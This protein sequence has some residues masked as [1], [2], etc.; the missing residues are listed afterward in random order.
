MKK[1]LPYILILI[2]LVGVFGYGQNVQAADPVGTCTVGTTFIEGISRTQC[3]A[4][5]SKPENK[6]VAV[7][8]RENGATTSVMI[9]YANA[10]TPIPVGSQALPT[11]NASPF[12]QSIDSGCQPSGIFSSDWSFGGCLLKF[13]YYFVFQLSSGLL[14][15]AAQIFN[16]LIAIVIQSKFY[17][18]PFISTAWVVVRDLSN[19]FFILV[20]LYIAVRTILGLGGHDT[21]KMITSV[22]IMALLIN[23]S[24]FFTRIVIDSSNILALIFYNKLD[25]TYE[26][27]PGVSANRPNT[28]STPYN[29]KDISGAMYKNFNATE[30][31]NDTFITKL[32]TQQVVQENAS[33]N[34]TIEIPSSGLPV[35]L[36]LLIMFVAGIIMF[37][38]AYVF[39]ISGLFFLGRLID[40]WVLMIFAPFAFMSF[41]VPSLAHVEYIGWDNWSKKLISTSFMAPIFMFFLY[42]IFQLLKG[43]GIFSDFTSGDGAISGML[44]VFI[45]ALIILGLLSKAKEFAKKGGGQFG[46]IMGKVGGLAAG[47]AIGGGVGLAAKSLQ[48]T[49]GYAGSKM[50]NEKNLARSQSDKWS[51]RVM[52]KAA[53]WTGKKAGSS[54]FDLRSGLA[55]VALKGVSTATGLN[56]GHGSK[57]LSTEKGGYIEDVKRRNDERL[58]EAE[59]VKHIAGHHA[60]EKVNKL[61]DKKQ[62]TMDA[63][64]ETGEDAGK[65]IESVL[66]K[67]AKDI[68][69]TRQKKK[70]YSNATTDEGKA[71]YKKYEE[72]LQ[73]LYAKKDRIQDG[74]EILDKEGKGTGRYYTENGN[75]SETE[76]KNA[77]KA[78]AAARARKESAET[79]KKAAETELTAAETAKKAA[80]SV[81]FNATTMSVTGPELEAATAEVAKM[82]AALAKALEART[83]AEKE[84]TAAAAN[85]TKTEEEAKR[86]NAI[87]TK[88]GGNTKNSI[89][90]IDDFLIPEAENKKKEAET[91]AARGYAKRLEEDWSIHRRGELMDSARNIRIKAKPKEAHKEKKGDDH[92]NVI[93]ELVLETGAEIAA[94]AVT[95]GDKGHEKTH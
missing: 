67:I 85:I 46:E 66:E 30:L 36:T 4:E 31:L 11:Q 24:L 25:V 55:G 19:V 38:A 43:G 3:T 47:L 65:S 86:V 23:F 10:P 37:V 52:G 40:L 59:E 8:W 54:S 17:D 71:A 33:G 81:L 70:D 88:H 39:F 15:V 56:L 60:E 18:K 94:G 7:F 72:K 14:Y 76:V 87:K 83:K 68:V 16:A 79:A 28:P 34:T 75:I 78:E 29:E 20:L 44:K 27:S 95:G 41:A 21:K 2:V 51:E 26:K 45:P 69:S 9:K 63:T 73:Q 50:I 90:E 91:A 22:V 13:V 93:D 35:G 74:K 80:D 48:A 77:E 1:F 58:K 42:L 84:E 89:N 57:I 82:E 32:K 6:S 12:Q 49:V 53:L 64:I 92:H 62:S 5:A 61:K